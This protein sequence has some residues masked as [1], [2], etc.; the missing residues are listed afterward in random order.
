MSK[1][2]T[3]AF[4]RVRGQ[5]HGDSA[6]G[7]F[8]GRAYT[9]RTRAGFSLQQPTP[10][11]RLRLPRPSTLSTQRNADRQNQPLLGPGRHRFDQQKLSGN[12]RFMPILPKR[13]HP[14]LLR[15]LAEP[16]PTPPYSGTSFSLRAGSSMPTATT[17]TSTYA[18]TSTK[19][20]AS[21]SSDKHE[22][23]LIPPLQRTNSPLPM[24]RGLIRG[25]IHSPLDDRITRGYR[26]GGSTMNQDAYHHQHTTDMTF[27]SILR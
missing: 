11:R 1:T 12:C 25:S 14:I 4:I 3:D 22:P 19:L 15:Q 17:F 7:G 13:H 23:R 6:K 27:L 9:T 21:T 26:I 24:A 16:T 8:S 18:T 5:V 10:A 20:S 2:K